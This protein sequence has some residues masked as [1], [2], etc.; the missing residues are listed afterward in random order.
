MLKVKRVKLTEGEKKESEWWCLHHKA[1]V[2]YLTTQ[3]RRYFDAVKEG[4]QK[5]A[6]Q[7]M[8][9]MHAQLPAFEKAVE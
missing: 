4:D 9:M 1:S 2:G 5:S 3:W 8:S 7:I 6:D